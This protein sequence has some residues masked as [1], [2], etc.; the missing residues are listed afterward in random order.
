MTDNDGS[1]GIGTHRRANRAPEAAISLAKAFLKDKFAH[2][3][4]IMHAGDQIME[5]KSESGVI[6]MKRVLA[7]PLSCQNDADGFGVWEQYGD[8]RVQQEMETALVALT[9]LLQE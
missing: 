1:F 8:L 9:V 4:M 6:F 3:E 2:Q 5:S 7:L